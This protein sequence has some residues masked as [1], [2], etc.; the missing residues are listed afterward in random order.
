MGQRER[1]E[2]IVGLDVG[3]TKICAVVGE[4]K[5]T[6]VDIIGVGLH[7]SVGLRKGVV[8]NIESTVASIRKAVEEA[9]LMAGCEISSVYVGIAGSHV[10]GLNSD[11]MIAV[12]DR[13]IRQ[14]DIDRVVEQAQA[15]SIPLDREVI[16][17]L[18][19]EFVL[20]GQG[21]IQNP[22]GMTG[23]RLEAR[24]HIVTGAVTAAHNLIKCCNQAGLDVSDIVLESLASAAAVLTPE[25]MEFGVA[26]LDI[27]GGTSDL[28]IFHGDAIKHT[29]VLGLGGNNLT[30]DL[31][32]G[33][34]TPI[35]EA[36]RLKINFGSALASLVEKDRSV[37]VP[38]VG[39]RKPRVLSQKVLGDILEPRV[40]E[41][42]T[43]VDQE[44][45]KANC[46]GLVTSGVVL[47][48]GT[49]QTR[50]IVEI[51]E[52]IFDLP[53]RVGTPREIG[54]LKGIVDS[55]AYATAVGLVLY[56]TRH[57]GGRKFRIRDEK[58]FGR[59][60]GRMK[61]WFGSLMSS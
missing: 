17:I 48:G 12:K 3:T 13:V 5:T 24:V 29:F 31:A 30:N 53:V 54:G 8:V 28:A 10:K 49:S 22:L 21:G 33:L 11:G 39:N 52:Q 50:H 35:N 38:S 1:G 40:E 42:I 25:E 61:R 6:G 16:H 32:V 18:P 51:A 34:R 36:E 14:A 26:L 56:G 4:A 43:I 59:V 7:P 45:V 60:A 37:E 46:K 55:P 9:E 44:M 20:D 27:G 2:L 23:V 58:I 15:L 41:I 57:E 47:T 19:Q